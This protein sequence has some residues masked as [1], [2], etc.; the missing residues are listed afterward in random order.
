MNTAELKQQAR[1]FGADLIGVAPIAA[2]RHLPA[3]HNPLAIFPQAESMIVIGRRILRGTLR[4]ME[5]RERRSMESFRHFG[6]LSLEDNYLARTTYDLGIWIEARGCEAVP[7]FGY[8]VEA[9]DRQPLGVPVAAGR[10]APNVYVDWKFAAAAA[11]LGTVGRHGLFLTPEYGPLQR[12]ALL[13]SDFCFEPTTASAP[14]D[15]CGDCRACLEACP[16]AAL[17]EEKRNDAVCRECRCGAIRTDIGRF[18]TV[19]RI[20]ADCSRACLAALA[21]AGKIRGNAA[22]GRPEGGF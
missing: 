6:F 14:Y 8:D 19:E 21:A 17:D 2:F 10:P 13:L 1:K 5:N 7:L 3:A 16:G 11:G 22:P 4:G 18:E 12:F 20:G 9:T 15:P